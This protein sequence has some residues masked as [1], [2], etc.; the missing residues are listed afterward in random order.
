MLA[1]LSLMLLN[2]GYKY[3]KDTSPS[4]TCHAD[5][6]TRRPSSIQ[7]PWQAAITAHVETII[8]R[9]GREIPLWEDSLFLDMA[10]PTHTPISPSQTSYPGTVLEISQ[11]LLAGLMGR[12]NGDIMCGP[13]EQEG[14]HSVWR[15]CCF[16]GRRESV[17]PGQR[18]DLYSEESRG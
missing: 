7:G 6:R 13:S 2:C 12:R 9:T 10:V 4:Q 3:S 16:K 5:R 18:E 11:R 15:S 8:I 14:S 17:H 1:P